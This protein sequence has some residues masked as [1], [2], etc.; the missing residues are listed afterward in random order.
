MLGLFYLYGGYFGKEKNIPFDVNDI[1]TEIEMPF[2]ELEFQ[3]MN[4]LLIHSGLL[5][6]LTPKEFRK[7]L[8]EYID[9]E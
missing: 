8:Q 9:D 7:I 1:L 5:H 2:T 4:Q 6:G 3:K